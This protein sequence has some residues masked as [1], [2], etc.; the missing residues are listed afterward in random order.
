MSKLILA[1][2]L[3]GW[4]MTLDEVPDPAFA[5]RMVGDGAAIDPVDSLLRAPCDGVITMI[6]R[7][8]HA[9]TLRAE[10][11]AEILLH[12]GIDTVGLEGEGLTPRVEQGAS[13][14]R[15]DVLVEID[16]DRLA[17]HAKSLV[18][19]IVVT[20]A[21]RFSVY[22]P[23]SGCLIE[24]G[25]PF[26]EIGRRETGDQTTRTAPAAMPPD[27][28]GETIVSLEH[29]FHARPAAR[30][31]RASRRYRSRIVFTARGREAD[32]GSTVALMALGV[33]CGDRV[34]L[35]GFGVDADEAVRALIEEISS[36]AGESP[37]R[38]PEPARTAQTAATGAGD[39][40]SV[41]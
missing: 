6:A 28:S 16:L 37:A 3:S 1:A 5:E 15:G 18:T 27:A 33:G 10:S 8:R 30:I 22:V 26:L 41:V 20:D 17:R 36:G 9:L 29:G 14:R 38:K 21:R 35:H 23:K 39:R 32:A 7:A 11:G 25:E 34:E 2:P 19:P 40:K 13:V 4:L 24:A 12:I 31:A